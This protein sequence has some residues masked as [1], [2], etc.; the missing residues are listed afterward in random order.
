MKLNTL[1]YIGMTT[2][3]LSSCASTLHNKITKEEKSD[4]MLI[5]VVGKTL[6]GWRE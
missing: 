2:L 5:L 3:F 1:F 6:N 4:G